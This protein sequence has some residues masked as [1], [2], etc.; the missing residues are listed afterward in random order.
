MLIICPAHVAVTSTTAASRHAMSIETLKKC[1]PTT[2]KPN[3]APV[4]LWPVTAATSQNNFF[5]CRTSANEETTGALHMYPNNSSK[6]QN[7]NEKLP[8]NSVKDKP[9]VQHFD[10]SEYI[11]LKGVCQHT[12]S[13]PSNQNGLTDCNETLMDS[14][15]QGMSV[16]ADKSEHGSV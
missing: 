3:V 11:A 9:L 4:R 12:T 1:V 14:R 2:A 7:R 6:L 8:H 15:H 13:N 5:P 10:R 16:H